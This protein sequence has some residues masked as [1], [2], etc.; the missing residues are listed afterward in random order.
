MVHTSLLLSAAFAFA[1]FAAPVAD[2]M[3]FEIGGN[4][5][6]LVKRQDYTQD[7]TSSGGVNFSPS[8][9]GYYVQYSNAQDFVVGR[10]WSKG[11]AR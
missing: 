2:P 10:G 7:Y 1:S 5:T 3:D 6:S 8:S 9:Q 4:L 11:A